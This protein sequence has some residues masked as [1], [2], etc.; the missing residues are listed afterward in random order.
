MT[1]LPRLNQKDQWDVW[2]QSR[3]HLALLA[4]STK[5]LLCP[6]SRNPSPAKAKKLLACKKPKIAG[7]TTTLLT[8]SESLLGK[9]RLARAKAVSTGSGKSILQE[10]L[11]ER[12]LA[13]GP[14]KS[15]VPAFSAPNIEGLEWFSGRTAAG[16]SMRGAQ[17]E[18]RGESCSGG[19]YMFKLLKNIITHKPKTQIKFRLHH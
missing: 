12:S 5:N 8:P 3:V 16:Q 13:L 15:P 9:V 18:E 19:P 14:L 10:L 11:A 17:R 1:R 6:A 7:P 4:R 2:F